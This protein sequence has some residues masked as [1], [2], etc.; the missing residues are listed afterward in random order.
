MKI[1]FFQ[2]TLYLAAAV[3]FPVLCN[4]QLKGGHLFGG[5]GLK[6]GT[7][8]PENTIT[9]LAVGYLYTAN[10][11]NNDAGDKVAS[12]D[13]NMFIAAPGFNWVSDFK[14]LGATYGAAALF[15]FASNRIEGNSIDSKSDFA[16]SDTYIQPVQLGW[17]RKKADFL[18]GYQLYIPTG[19][20]EYGGSGNSGLGM[21]INEFTAGTTV[22][23]DPKKEWHIASNFSYE[24]HGKKKDT[25]VK[26]G[27]ILNVEGGFGKTFYMLN[28]EKTAPKSIINAG[29]IYYM[30][31]KMTSDEIPVGSFVF[32][33]DKDRVIALGLEGNFLHLAS[34]TSVGF[35]WFGEA[36]AINRFKGNTFFLTLAHIF[37]TKKAK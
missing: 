32:T 21:W 4:A 6:S 11:L 13:F 35:R 14:I 5:A 34:K 33:G 2:S 25:D 20:Y 3:L 1:S 22:Y 18:F 10:A 26:T 9:A 19:K 31:Y 23:L 28:S 12:P 16:Y 36:H 15:P 30:Q 17:A 27:D 24:I 37:S 7:Q 8:A 29:L